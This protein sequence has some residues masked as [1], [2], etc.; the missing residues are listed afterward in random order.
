MYIE[1]VRGGD[2]TQMAAPP[3]PPP[4]P[5]AGPVRPLEVKTDLSFAQISSPASLSLSLS[6]SGVKF[7]VKWRKYQ[8]KSRFSGS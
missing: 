5:P 6:L 7:N 3:P 4:A 8:R 1:A 2:V